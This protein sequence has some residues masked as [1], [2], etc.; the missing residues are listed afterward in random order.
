M[1]SPANGLL[2]C[3]HLLATNM[4]VQIFVQVSAFSSFMYIP[5]SGIAGYMVILCLIFWRPTLLFSTEALHTDSNFSAFSGTLYFLV[6]FD[7]SYLDVCEVVCISFKIKGKLTK[8]PPSPLH[9]FYLSELCLLCVSEPVSG[10]GAGTD[11][12]QLWFVRGGVASWSTWHCRGWTPEQVF[13][14]FGLTTSISW[15]LSCCFMFIYFIYALYRF[16]ICYII[17]MYVYTQ[18]YY[19]HF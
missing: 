5:R 7:N 8:K 12:V 2:G 9:S 10:K 14:W 15:K 3:F 17:Y 4:G 1:H 16:Y 18:Y 11:L 19:I 13:S 6:L